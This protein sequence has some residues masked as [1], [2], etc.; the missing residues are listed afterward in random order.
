[1]NFD[2]D[3]ASHEAQHIA[4]F[5]DMAQD[6]LAQIQP[7]P[8]GKEDCF[9]S[10]YSLVLISERIAKGLMKQ[11]DDGELEAVRPA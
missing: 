7:V 11:L 1:M 10:L 4:R 6:C 8:E 2:F 5:M 3:S 9:E